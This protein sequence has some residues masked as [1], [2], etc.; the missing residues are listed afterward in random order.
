MELN[1]RLIDSFVVP[2]MPPAM[3]SFPYPVETE[4]STRYIP[5]LPSAATAAV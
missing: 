3:R 2:E 5:T 1:A 4:T